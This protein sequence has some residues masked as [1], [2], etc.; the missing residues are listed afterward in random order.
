MRFI[1]LVIGA[2]ATGAL[3]VFGLQAF[4][5]QAAQTLQAATAGGGGPGVKL[6]DL[7][8]VTQAYDYVA[9]Q[10]TSGRSVDL[11]GPPPPQVVTIGPSGY[12]GYAP[13]RTYFDNR[14]IH[15]PWTGDVNR[16]VPP[17]F[18]PT[19]AYHPAPSISHHAAGGH[20]GGGHGRR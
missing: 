16:H 12:V 9:R 15:R 19:H 17:V 18:Q 11:L 1:L 3:G 20:G 13:V 4:S 10:I 7:N 6:S 8:P 14:A 5:P 2:A